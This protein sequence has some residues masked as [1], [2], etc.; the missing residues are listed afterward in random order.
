MDSL[1]ST[2][3][4]SPVVCDDDL[5]AQPE[6]GTMTTSN[7][8]ARGTVTPGPLA[9]S[10]LPVKAGLASH[11]TQ[12]EGGHGHRPGLSDTSYSGSRRIGYTTGSHGLH[13]CGAPGESQDETHNA[14]LQHFVL[15]SL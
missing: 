1:P 6:A 7:G 4:R 11:G 8:P 12:P 9:G 14:A 10:N 13:L 3:R 5:S 2:L 15:L